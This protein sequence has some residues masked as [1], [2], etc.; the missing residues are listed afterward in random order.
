[1]P[2]LL[3]EPVVYVTKN[4]FVEPEDLDPWCQVKS[5]R[6]SA[7]APAKLSCP[8]FPENEAA[9]AVPDKKHAPCVQCGKPKRK[10]CRH[11]L[12]HGVCSKNHN[13]NYCHHEVEDGGASDG[14]GQSLGQNSFW[15]GNVQYGWQNPSCAKQRLKPSQYYPRLLKSHPAQVIAILRPL[16]GNQDLPKICPETM[17]VLLEAAASHCGSAR[18]ATKIAWSICKK[19]QWYLSQVQIAQ[20]NQEAMKSWYLSLRVAAAE[21]APASSNRADLKQCDSPH[22]FQHRSLVVSRLKQE[23]FRGMSRPRVPNLLD[24][25]HSQLGKS[26]P[27]CLVPKVPFKGLLDQ[28]LWHVALTQ[29]SKYWTRS[30]PVTTYALQEVLEPYN[31]MLTSLASGMM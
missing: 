12:A 15:Y 29:L 8:H 2:S 18:L 19:V 31:T 4:T 6:R 14:T 7:S 1:M 24:R 27:D 30:M 3:L 25:G 21:V 16:V 13:C 22:E 26:W 17:L 5:G 9:A 10:S 20:E 11:W 23:H 28:F